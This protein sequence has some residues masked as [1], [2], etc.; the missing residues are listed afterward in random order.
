MLA[1]EHDLAIFPGP[2]YPRGGEAGDH[3]LEAGSASL[4]CGDLGGGA[5]LQPD[6]GPHLEVHLV[7]DLVVHPHD[8]VTHVQGAVVLLHVVDTQGHDDLVID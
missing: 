5:V 6:G 8:H 3:A 4:N 1:I 7:R 2:V